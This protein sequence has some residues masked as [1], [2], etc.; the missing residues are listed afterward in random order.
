MT[1]KQMSKMKMIHIY[2]VQ[3]VRLGMRKAARSDHEA[4]QNCSCMTTMQYP[5]TLWQASANLASD[6]MIAKKKAQVQRKDNQ[7]VS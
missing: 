7:V 2:A 3:L 5:T 1:S 4:A 6:P